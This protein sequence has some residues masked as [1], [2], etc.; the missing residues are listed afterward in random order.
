[1]Y[2]NHDQW[3][4]KRIRIERFKVEGVGASLIRNLDKKK[5]NSPPSSSDTYVK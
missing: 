1:M 2:D 4:R 3:R 5:N